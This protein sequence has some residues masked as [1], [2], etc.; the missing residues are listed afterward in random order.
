MNTFQDIILKLLSFWTNEGC[1]LEQS[2]DCEVG[3]GTFNPST[4]LRSLGPEP[5]KTVFVE[6]CRR[7]QDGRYGQNPNRL[8]LFHQLQVVIKPFN[9]KAQ[10][11]YLQSLE[12]IGFNLSN[13]DIRFVHDDWESPTLGAWG[14]GWEV[15]IDGMEVTQFTYFQS[16]A[17]VNLPIIS[18]ELAYGLE[19]L[20]MLL[21]KSANFFDMQWND[22]LTYG[23]LCKQSE[24]EWSM[25]NFDIANTHL[26]SKHFE[27]YEKE[28][29][30][31]LKNDTPISGYDF[32]IK[33]SHAFNMLEARGVL[34]TT[35]RKGY[36]LR[37]RQLAQKVAIQYLEKREKMGFPLLEIDKTD[38]ESPIIPPKKE[39]SFNSR[40][41]F[42]FEIG[43][44]E[45]PALYVKEAIHSLKELIVSFLK[46]KKLSFNSIRTYETEK[47]L[48]IFISGLETH[49]PS[50]TVEK[51]GP[52]LS[53]AFDQNGELTQQ[54]QGFFKSIGIDKC[55]QKDIEAKTIE[56]LSTIT[57][58]NNTYLLHTKKETG[59]S[60][61]SLFRDYLKNIIKKISFKKKMHWNDTSFLYARPIKWIIAL[62]GHEVIPFSYG[63]INS[64]RFTYGHRQRAFKQISI[65]HPSEY[66][67]KLLENKVMAC[68]TKRREYLEKQ[69]TAIEKTEE[70]KAVQKERLINEI[71]YLSEWPE[72]ALHSFDKSFLKIPDPIIVSE[73]VEHQRCIPLTNKAKT[74]VNAYIFVSDNAINSEILANNTSVLS[75]RLADGVFLYEQDLK[76]SLES[77]ADKLKNITFQKDLGSMYEKAV[78]MQYHASLLNTL[79]NVDD[80]VL[81]K[82]AALLS[83]ADLVSSLVEEFPDLQGCIGKYYAKI[84]N[85]PE[86]IALSMEEHWYPKSEQSPLPSTPF[87][88]LISLADKFDNLIG[89]FSTGLKPTS[90]SDP[91]GLKRQTLAIIKILIDQ[92]WSCNLREI[93][94]HC[95]EKF[96]H[97]SFLGEL[98]E[99]IIT[100]ILEYL[101]KRSLTA[102]QTYGFKK[103]EIEAALFDEYLDPY[104]HYLR[105]KSVHEYTELESL[106]ILLEVYDRLCGQLKDQ[107]SYKFE[108]KKLYE[109]AEKSLY[110]HFFK[111]QSSLN[112][113]K[114]EKNYKEYLT[115]L[116]SLQQPLAQFFD[117][118]KVLHDEPKIME[119][120]IALLQLIKAPFEGLLD[121][122]R[123]HG[124]YNK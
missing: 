92:K 29:D 83:K 2:H 19:R 95:L 116:S 6:P 47:R 82:R 44:E 91:Y 49:Q 107:N 106:P 110:E 109:E 80:D 85:E 25:Y 9:P 20:S 75:A 12:A 112:T 93:I 89:Y 88:A 11:L 69:I 94:E 4:F 51:R 40:E 48:T 68:S 23:Q 87:T 111:I 5:F 114:S 74:L 70:S 34:S 101:G 10:D 115:L 120:R 90:S 39:P 104:D 118:V 67:Q 60:T 121:F 16:V 14:L 86:Q 79:F 113:A 84:H 30:L 54:G 57:I 102:L 77:M 50:L 27:E 108:P 72:P 53:L 45:L 71:L 66:E 98:K 119:N 122:E 18:V 42:L 35:E 117:Q 24:M 105:T 21:Q 3:A 58:K 100:E 15:W 17:G 36:I 96:Q 123:M 97:A 65:D 59:D 38:S 76:I 43:S 13:H 61:Y 56:G 64:N 62:I 1:I 52:S 99:K 22:S 73:L 33:S 103:I 7:P 8:Q 124:L 32:V 31:C 37:I 26:W 55:T 81:I 78:R 46:E 63:K 28:V 41:D